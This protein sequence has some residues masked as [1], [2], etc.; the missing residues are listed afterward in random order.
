MPTRL[1]LC[2]LIAC[3]SA[4]AA[5]RDVKHSSPNG[6]SCPSQSA[7][8]ETDASAKDRLRPARATAPVREARTRPALHSDS[9]ARPSLRWHSFLPGMFR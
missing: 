9:P 7:E 4:G 3:A 2:L 1:C 5:A 8:A 6:G